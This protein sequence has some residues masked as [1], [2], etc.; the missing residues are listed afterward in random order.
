M[1]NQK[2]VAKKAG[3][4]SA[5]VSAVINKNKYVSDNLKEKVLKAINELEYEP[6]FIARSLKMSSTN[7]IGIVVGNIVSQAFS[8]MA[9]AVENV[10]K[11]YGFNLIICNSDDNPEKELDCLK[12]L[13][14]KR[15]EGIILI[16]TGKNLNYVKK[17]IRRGVFFVFADRFLEGL[18]C[19][20]ILI[21][22]EIGAYNGTK[23]L[24]EEGFSKIGFIG[25]PLEI[26]TGKERFNGYIKAL[27]ENGIGVEEELIKIGTFKKNGGILA[28]S[29]LMMGSV[30]PDAIIS[31]NL[32]LTLG[33]LIMLKHLGLSIPNDI[34]LI[35][36]EDSDWFKIIDPSITVIKHPLYGFGAIAAKI[37]LDRILNNCDS[38]E[39]VLK[40]LPTKLIIRNSTKR[41]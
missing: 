29:E 21:D 8:I 41:L 2:D 40:R 36:F 15:V 34:S 20:S 33:A 31:T 17:L 3:V 39:P 37:L 24:I 35:S 22:N 9:K 5:T 1:V 28:I 38:N 4:S 26:T 32:D 6:N 19:D 23:Y 13:S 25:G 7:S 18:N 11:K 12:S 16:P 10:A 27:K 30:K 14:S